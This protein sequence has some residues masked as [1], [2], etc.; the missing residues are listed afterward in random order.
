MRMMLAMVL[1]LNGLWLAGLPAQENAGTDKRPAVEKPATSEL[2]P[3]QVR[4]LAAVLKINEALDS[5]TKIDVNETPL[6]DVLNDIGKAHKII[7]VLDPE[8]CDIA[9]V[10]PDQ[11]VNVTLSKISLRNA[12]R[13]L[14]K[15]LQLGYVVRHEVLTIT[16]LDCPER[17]ATVRTFAL[18]DLLK[19]MDD[20]SEL[21]STLET[22]WPEDEE[23]LGEDKL[24]EPR[25]RILAGHLVVRGSPRHLDLAEQLIDGLMMQ[26]PEPEEKR[27]GSSAESPRI[28][29]VIEPEKPLL[30][31]PPPKPE[32][33]DGGERR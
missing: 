32:P 7:V 10:T 26:R 3:A 22:I 11:L 14:L 28:K 19:R 25:A 27:D 31:K 23:R 8:G 6:A 29:A 24:C 1:V 4:E 30:R 15:P 18:G 20:P 13:A 21:I 9:G 16:S 5:E 12:L 33:D 2:T 17:L